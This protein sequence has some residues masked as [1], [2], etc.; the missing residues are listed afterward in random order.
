V[1]PVPLPWSFVQWLGLAA[2]LSAVAVDALG[3]RGHSR[4]RGGFA[5]AV[6]A[7][8]AYAALLDP[9]SRAIDT[10][11]LALAL[12]AALAGLAAGGLAWLVSAFLPTR[13]GKRSVA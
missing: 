9:E 7:S 4:L 6:G 2:A 11:T 8:V 3:L 10:T 1:R 13:G 5:A 12:L